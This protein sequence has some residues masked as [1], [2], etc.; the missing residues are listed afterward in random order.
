MEARVN[1]CEKLLRDTLGPFEEWIWVGGTKRRTFY[2]RHFGE[3][4]PFPALKQQCIC[5]VEIKE[6]CWIEHKETKQLE[7]I[8]NCCVKRFLPVGEARLLRCALCDAPHRNR[9]HNL[10]TGHMSEA[11]DLVRVTIDDCP[12]CG[13]RC[14]VELI[15]DMGACKNCR[16]VRGSTREGREKWIRGRLQY[17]W[18]ATA[19]WAKRGEEFVPREVLAPLRGLRPGDPP[20]HGKIQIALAKYDETAPAPEPRKYIARGGMIIPI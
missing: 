14:I 19:L 20:A 6:Q 8:G 4:A 9:K 5:G 11:A 16:W 15:D 1:P 12:C 18:S 10:C 7:T 13:E 2:K 3:D 17:G